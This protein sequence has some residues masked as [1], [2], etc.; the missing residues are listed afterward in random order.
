MANRGKKRS[1]IVEELPADKR[2]CSSLEFRPSSSAPSAQ[3]PMDS[4]HEA[5]DAD[6]DTSS[7][8]SGSVK[9]EGHVE[10]ESAY[11]SCDSDN[12][13]H[14]YNGDRSLSDRSKFKKILSS[15]RKEVEESGQLALLS[16]ICELLVFCGDDSL[17]SQM[18]DSFSPVLVKLAR[19]E[20]SPDIMLLAIRAITYMCD[21][22]D[23]SSR[24]LVRHD[25]VPV[26]CQRLLTIEYLDVAEQCL[27]ALEK[28]SREQPMACLRSGAIMAAL[29][30]IDFFSTT[31]QRVA[32]STV[33]NICKKLSSDSSPHFM[34]AVPILCNL[35]QC[36]DKQLVESAATCL[37]RI[38]EQLYDSPNMLEEICNHG[39]VHQTLH[40]I[41][42]NGRTT[43]FQPTYIGLIELLRKLVARSTLAF[44]ML[45]ELDISKT[46]KE[47]LYRNEVSHGMQ[48]TLMVDGRHSQ[49]NE[50]L[51]LLNELLPAVTAE[52]DDQPKSDK[53]VFLLSHPDILR[54]FGVDLLP[55]LIQIVNSGM[56][57]FTC[58]GCLSVINKLVHSSTSDALCSMLQS[59]NFSRFLA[60]IFMRKDKHVILL[61]LQIVDTVMFKLPHLYL[62]SFIKEGILF[63]ICALLSPDKDLKLSSVFD[64]IRFETDATLKSDSRD[65]HRCPC[66]AFDIGQSSKSPEN[67]TCKLKKSTSQD[68]AKRIWITYFGTESI[69]PEKGVTIILQKLRTLST[70]LTAQVNRFLEDASSQQ[71]EGI[72]DILHEIMSEL[73]ETD[74]ISTFEFVESGIIKAL[75]SYLSNGRHLVGEEDINAANYLRRMEKRFEVF[76]RRLLSCPDPAR[77]ESPLLTLIQ[78]L[79]SALSSVE[80]FPVIL[81]QRCKPRDSYA[82]VP[83]GRYISHMCLKVQFVRENGE[84]CLRDYAKNVVC[85]DPFVRLEEIEGYLRPR[86]SNDNTKNL[87]SG[88]KDSKEKDSLCSY[89]PPD[90]STSQGENQDDLATE[91]MQVDI[92]TLQKGKPSSPSSSPAGA[93]SFAHTTLNSADVAEVSTVLVEQVEH[94]HLQEDGDTN[95]GE[96]ENRNTSTKLLFYLEGQ[97]LNSQLTLYQSILG[98]QKEAEHGI[99]TS[100][101]LWT[102]IYKITYRR[103]TSSPPCHSKR[104]LDERASF[105]QCT[106]FFSSIFPQVAFEK[107]DP[108]YDVLSLLKILEVMNKLRFRL[109]FRDRTYRFVKGKINDLDKLNV[110]VNGVPANEFVNKKLTEKL[111]QQMRDLMSISVGAMPAWCTQLMDWCPFLFS[112]EAR[113][114]YFHLAALGRLPIQTHST[115]EDSDLRSSGRR[116]NHGSLSRKK[117][118]VHRDKILESAARMMELHPHHSVFEVEYNEEVGTGLGP[119]LEFYALVCREFQRNGLGMWRDDCV[120][121]HCTGDFQTENSGTLLSPFGLFPR[122]WAPSTST[123]SSTVYSE[124]IKNFTLLGYVAAKAVQDGRVLDIPFSKAFYK[125]IL[126]EDLTLY[127]IP[128]FDPA[129]GRALLEFQAIVEKKEYLASLCEKN[130]HDL[131]VR[132]RGTKI[133][134][135]CLDFTLPG[136]L[137]YA[138]DS[139]SKMVNLNNLDEYVT[140]TVDAT[141]KSGIVRQ[142]EAFKSGFDQVFPIRH[143]RLFTEE[144][145]ERLLCGEHVLWNSDEL[146]DHIKFDHGYTASSPPIVNL[147]ELMKEFDLNQQRA[148]LQFVTGAPRLP[149]GGLASLKPKLT[150]VRKP[151][152][153]GTDADL[154]SVMTCANYLKLPPYSSKSGYHE[155]EAFICHNRGPGIV[156]PF[157]VS[158]VLPGQVNN[159]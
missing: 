133:E 40:L 54:K 35:L 154:P 116:Q 73:T 95:S 16:E 140:L 8:A 70:A 1:E 128:S 120:S 148:F 46:C 117:I 121:R 86:V 97:Q 118:L 5:R 76:G 134:D 105:F 13:L 152:S 34:E 85:V 130:S 144:E 24:F 7:S 66:F 84:V 143:L 15:L 139:N 91:E 36:E 10:K 100:N 77:E 58:Y 67:G 22:N 119:T 60:G 53:E 90:S 136:Y 103:R 26:L 153:M 71:E 88:S 75:V 102:N 146:S 20:S 96:S 115:S 63:A 27:Q 17:S 82:T 14:E 155:G 159:M 29:T 64:G 43:L 114:N 51:K 101:S 122:P 37:I 124:V 79:Q 150:I 135:I 94:S 41:G 110:V 56:N 78:R 98:Q 12:S 158:A 127:D 32:L 68:L 80:N 83:Y 108:A 145:L 113:C 9:S 52:Q 81:S 125:L 89:S 126:G 109:I 30:Y 123:L 132:L 62:N 6:M 137:D 18:L 44:R 106:P 74:S 19:H 112:F 157:I 92:H 141:T 28:L 21:Q 111:E 147:L 45:F 31:V 142:V 39:L 25:A 49:I 65:V 93:P 138:L 50:V 4:A 59:A 48:S 11:T 2:A 131:D 72:Y 42:L 33:V 69:D 129:F 107:S 104:C 156:P 151:F 149:T 57:L 3:T 38:G 99:I 61:A 87:T 23:R 47:M 55:I